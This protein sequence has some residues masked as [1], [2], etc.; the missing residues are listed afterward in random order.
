MQMW[1]HGNPLVEAVPPTGKVSL[2]ARTSVQ[3]KEA[4]GARLSDK[5]P[6]HSHHPSG[7]FPLPW[8]LKVHFPEK[9]MGPGRSQEV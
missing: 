4:A 2:V 5:P 3:P 8:Y 6:N 7:C 9:F 1:P